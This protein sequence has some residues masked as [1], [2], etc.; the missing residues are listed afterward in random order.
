MIKSKNVSFNNNSYVVT[1]DGKTVRVYQ[2]SEGHSAMNMVFEHTFR[3]VSEAK[4]WMAEPQ[5]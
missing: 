2:T 4:K 3:F 1:R 5:W